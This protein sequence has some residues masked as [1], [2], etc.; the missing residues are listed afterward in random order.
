MSFGQRRV[1][2]HGAD[3]IREDIR[4]AARRGRVAADRQLVAAGVVL[5]PTADPDVGTVPSPS[6]PGDDIPLPGERASGGYLDELRVSLTRELNARDFV[7]TMPLSDP[8]HWVN[9]TGD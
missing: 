6:T 8:M 9:L 1:L 2:Q 5:V 7:E 4:E 3:A